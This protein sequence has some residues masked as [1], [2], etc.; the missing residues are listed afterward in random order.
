MDKNTIKEINEMDRLISNIS[1]SANLQIE[2]VSLLSGIWNNI[3]DKLTSNEKESNIINDKGMQSEDT[4]SYSSNFTGRKRKIT[5]LKKTL[6]PKVVVPDN[7]AP[8]PYIKTRNAKNL[9]KSNIV[10]MTTSNIE[11]SN[12]VDDNHEKYDNSKNKKKT[13]I[14]EIK[15]MNKK[16]PLNIEIQ[17]SKR[18]KAV[19][20]NKNE[21]A[22]KSK[23]KR[24]NENNN[25]SIDNKECMKIQMDNNFKSF[26][27][28]SIDITSEKN[29]DEFTDTIE[30]VSSIESNLKNNKQDLTNKLSQ[31]IE[32]DQILS[33]NENNQ[34]ISNEEEKDKVD[35]YKNEEQNNNQE[36]KRNLSDD[37]SNEN[38]PDNEN[39]IST[40]NN[41]DDLNN[42]NRIEN[43]KMETSKNNKGDLSN[44]PIENR[45]ESK[46][47]NDDLNNKNCNENIINEDIVISKD[48]NLSKENRVEI[49]NSNEDKV[50]SKV[51]LQT[52]KDHTSSIENYKSQ[53]TTI[54][55]NI[56][57]S[58]DKESK[59]DNTISNI[60][61][62][63][64]VNSVIKNKN[65]SILSSENLEL[66]NFRVVMKDNT[67]NEYLNY[68][69]FI[70]PPF[71]NKEEY[72]YRDF[73]KSFESLKLKIK[74]HS[75]KI[76]YTQ[77]NLYELILTTS[78]EI[79]NDTI[80]KSD[81]YP[82]TTYLIKKN[83]NLDKKTKETNR[84]WV[85]CSTFKI[86]YIDLFN[87]M[88]SVYGS[89]HIISA[90]INFNKYDNDIYYIFF[91][92]GSGLLS[93]LRWEETKNQYIMSYCGKKLIF[94][95]NK[96]K[97]K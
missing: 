91:T 63:S 90:D 27:V 61:N 33:I 74:V 25:R 87:Y 42:K 29:N 60:S 55:A 83:N 39:L 70:T 53:N 56:N 24:K 46:N 86:V 94:R 26:N 3:K 21:R 96:E 73:M 32:F 9:N 80:I 4:D 6:S 52:N 58:I 20:D 78:K 82:E 65:L 50:K 64:S 18:N 95:P 85:D 17:K 75:L 59:F 54:K 66:N 22:V 84:Y 19:S 71:R 77:Q 38:R 15:L 23:S 31:N 44:E 89:N 81:Q 72:D 69:V 68:S 49:E 51:Y 30:N 2:N 57:S 45:N 48:N 28:E 34:K 76:C 8:F 37:L 47:N 40:K 13:A 35:E 97:K 41:N 10:K 7:I 36:E 11:I 12:I 62:I 43:E 88:K 16:N 67:I 1:H 93:Y 92:V 5:K 79:Q 14:K